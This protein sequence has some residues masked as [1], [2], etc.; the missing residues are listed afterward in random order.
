MP[1][2]PVSVSLKSTVKV[3]LAVMWAGPVVGVP[4]EDLAF[5]CD[6]QNIGRWRVMCGTDVSTR[7]HRAIDWNILRDAHS[8]VSNVTI[9]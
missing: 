5:I 3:S 7:G 9:G 4:S 2:A 8:N 1:K 6:E